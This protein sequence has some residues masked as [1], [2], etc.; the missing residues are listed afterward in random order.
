MKNH[1]ASYEIFVFFGSDPNKEGTYA[2][3]TK[4]VDFESEKTFKTYLFRFVG[5]IIPW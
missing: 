5:N 1:D 3:R 4:Y 2:Y